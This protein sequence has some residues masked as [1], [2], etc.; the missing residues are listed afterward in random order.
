MHDRADRIRP[1]E[2]TLRPTHHLDPLDVGHGQVREVEPTS[3]GVDPDAI[4]QHQGRVGFTAP[5]KQRREAASSTATRH[6]QARD[7]LQG[8]RDGLDLSSLEIR[9]ADDIDAIEHLGQGAVHVR[10]RHDDRFGDRADPQLDPDVALLVGGQLE[11]YD[12]GAKAIERDPQLIRPWIE[13]GDL[14]PAAVV[15]ERGGD[16][17]RRTRE[18]DTCAGCHA[19]IRID[20]HA[21]HAGRGGEAGRERCRQSEHENERLEGSSERHRAPFGVTTRRTHSP[22]HAGKQA[23]EDEPSDQVS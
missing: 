16:R 13:I 14:E 19:A 1:V 20:D 3:E 12:I 5:R 11:R 2:R 22:A 4:D 23:E 9:R 21:L 15:G 8:A 18:Q 7:P 6:G 17:R 10:G